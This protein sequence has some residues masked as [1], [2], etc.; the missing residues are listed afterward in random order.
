MVTNRRKLNFLLV[1]LSIAPL[2]LQLVSIFF[3]RDDL[4]FI[5]I[6]VYALVLILGLL[7]NNIE[8]IDQWFLE[9]T[10][11]WLT[12]NLWLLN[13][14]DLSGIVSIRMPEMVYQFALLTTTASL[15]FLERHFTFKNIVLIALNLNC[16]AYV[17]PPAGA[18]GLLIAAV[19]MLLLYLERFLITFTEQFRLSLLMVYLVVAL[20]AAVW[21]MPEWPMF[22]FENIA[23]EIEAIALPIILLIAFLIC[24]AH[25]RV[26]ITIHL[27]FSLACFTLISEI[28]LF[29]GQPRI[30]NITYLTFCLVVYI[31]L[32]NIFGSIYLDKDHRKISVIIPAHDA[33]DTIVAALESIKVQ[34]YR[35]WEVIIIDDGSTDKTM[36]YLK[37]YLKYNEMPVKY[38]SVERRGR[39]N[40]IRYALRY[41]NGDICYVLDPQ[42][43]LYD[44][45]VFYRAVSSLCGEK[46]DGIFVGIQ[47]ESRLGKIHQI[48]RSSAYYD[49]RTTV[50][51]L[52]LNEGSDLFVP[53]TYRRKKTFE[54]S[55]KKNYLRNNLPAWYNAKN[56]LGLRMANANFVGLRCA[57]NARLKPAD[58]LMNFSGQLRTLHHVLAN[59]KIEAFFIQSK[60]YK[61]LRY[62]HLS[63][64]GLIFFKMGRT[65]LKHITPKII[66]KSG[67]SGL[68]LETIADFARNYDP[69]KAIEIILPAKTKIYDGCDM[70]KFKKD[71]ESQQLD[72]F[73]LLFMKKLAQGPGIIMV[74]R[75]QKA[76]VARILE[77]FTIKD[78]VKLV[79]KS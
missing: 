26:L 75:Q 31:N 41:V 6:T 14:I 45:R 68:Y 74:E 73:Y 66:Q 17:F 63:T 67:H 57:S 58:N 65:K 78:Y 38:Y 50:V 47:E 64:M 52:A 19:I 69:Q 46:C 34:T 13:I 32:I 5:L 39:L 28:S 33:Q 48:V 7:A 8:D 3:E 1:W 70:E 36:T 4:N 42:D 71:F 22:S 9:K 29:I 37:R 51:K 20:I 40:A 11:T 72:E 15:Y 43:R 49:S 61:I 54:S 10:T 25:E 2:Y 53:Y 24:R 21:I 55:V 79:D 59:F 44:K 77:F 23:W 18:W 35:N 76:R 56:N 16:L 62:L 27:V 30:L 12:V 60:V